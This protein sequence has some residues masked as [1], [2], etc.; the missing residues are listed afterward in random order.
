[1]EWRGE[2]DRLERRWGDWGCGQGRLGG[3]KICGDWGHGG[4]EQ[5]STQKAEGKV[6]WDSVSM[7][8]P[9]RYSEPPSQ[10]VLHGRRQSWGTV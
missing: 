7:S 8:A 5:D 6:A 4:G 1:M 3:G 9:D 10:A 2:E